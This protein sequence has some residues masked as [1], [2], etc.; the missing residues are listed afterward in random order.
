MDRQLAAGFL[1]AK[2]AT[3]AKTLARASLQHSKMRVVELLDIWA[4]REVHRKEALEI[5]QPLL[6]VTFAML[7]DNERV[8][9]ERLVRLLATRYGGSGLSFSRDFDASAMHATVRYVLTKLALVRRTSPKQLSAALMSVAIM[10]LR[11]LIGPEAMRVPVPSAPDARLLGRLRLRAGAAGKEPEL[12]SNDDPDKEEE[13]EE[14]KNDGD[15]KKDGDDKDADAADADAAVD[16]TDPHVHRTSYS[17]GVAAWLGALMRPM[18]CASS[19]FVP[20]PFVTM[21]LQRVPAVGWAVLESALMLGAQALESRGRFEPIGW[22]HELMSHSAG[23]LIAA[24]AVDAAVGKRVVAALAHLL[25][26]VVRCVE[27][28]PN[29]H[30][31][32][33]GVRSLA[34]CVRVSQRLLSHCAP[35][36]AA[37]LQAGAAADKKEAAR[38]MLAADLRA[39]WHGDELVRRLGIVYA[40]AAPPT[41]DVI[42]NSFCLVFDI[43]V[44]DTV[45]AILARRKKSKQ[46]SDGAANNTAPPNAKKA[47][48]TQKSKHQQQQHQQKQQQETT[49]PEKQ[50]NGDEQPS[51]KR[52]K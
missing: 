41:A 31:N 44:P 28:T 13:E 47:K 40:G 48:K 2:K 16:L 15:D 52:R 38:A 35:Q 19:S 45:L 46:R 8:T 17:A 22:L 33:A 24:T 11:V 12:D 26:L 4:R 49:T 20:K 50:A 30:D 25:P 23:N 21:L 27:E 32:T 5:L 18:I 42:K 10:L 9:G 37:T 3:Q 29:P 34:A 43:P 39:M 14:E 7:L 51:K 1:A 36:Y 6:D